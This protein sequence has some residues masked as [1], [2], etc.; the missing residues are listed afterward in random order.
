MKYEDLVKKAIEMLNNNDDLFVEMVNELDN[1]NGFAD[2]FR[3]YDMCELDDL[4]SG[5]TPTE[6]LSD[7]CEDFNINDNYFYYDIWG[8]HSADYIEV[9]Y[10]D[11]T[12]SEEVFDNVLENLCNIYISDSDFEDLMNEIDNFEEE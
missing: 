2:C 12:S 11:N 6:I 7:I 5:K 8:L 4:L 1:W 3:C 9:V 10:R